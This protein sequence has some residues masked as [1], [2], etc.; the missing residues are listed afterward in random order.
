MSD[1][2]FHVHHWHNNRCTWPRVYCT[3]CMPLA[4]VPLHRMMGLYMAAKNPL[5]M[6]CQVV[7]FAVILC[8]ELSTCSVH[9][10]RQRSQVYGQQKPP[11]K[12]R[13]EQCSSCSEFSR[14]M[15]V[16][17]IH[18]VKLR[19]AFRLAC[20]HIRSSGKLKCWMTPMTPVA[21]ARGM[22]VVAP[23]PRTALHHL[24]R[25]PQA[26]RSAL[27]LATAAALPPAQRRRNCI[28]S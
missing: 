28:A 13:T 15:F 11:E 16:I 14:S 23:H 17:S 25:V 4:R 10:E 27:Q 2:V 7:C 6:W 21:M 24:L 3:C 5:G 22:E 19:W 20:H 26:S 18:P 9:R 1:L 12:V 8:A